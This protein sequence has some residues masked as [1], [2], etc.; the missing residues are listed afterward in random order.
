MQ[1]VRRRRQ[2]SPNQRHVTTTVNAKED[3][4]DYS[5]ITPT[6][7]KS[8]RGG[9]SRY[10][11]PWCFYLSAIRQLRALQLPI[12]TVVL[13]GNERSVAS[14]LKRRPGVTWRAGAALVELPPLRLLLMAAKKPGNE[15]L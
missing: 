14:Y 7:I 6:P 2:R 9:R 15:M 3:Q 12:S 8:N 4:P 11:R 10:V 13:T 5:Q 1:Y